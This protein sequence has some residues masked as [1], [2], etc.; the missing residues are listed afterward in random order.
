MYEFT[1][2][3]CIG[4]C[5]PCEISTV[6]RRGIKGRNYTRN[7]NDNRSKPQDIKSSASVTSTPSPKSVHFVLP[8]ESHSS[9]SIMGTLSP[10]TANTSPYCFTRSPRKASRRPSSLTT[11]QGD[12]LPPPKSP[13][14]AKSRRMDGLSG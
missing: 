6:Q 1:R 10:D 8:D 13:S 14:A 5:E 11:N 2:R 7:M 3:S 4:P 12:F 9:Q